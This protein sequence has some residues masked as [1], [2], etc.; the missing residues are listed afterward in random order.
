MQESKGLDAVGYRFTIWRDI[1]RIVSQAVFNNRLLQI[2][3]IAQNK[4]LSSAGT[5]RWLGKRSWPCRS[6]SSSR[7]FS[8]TS[9]KTVMAHPPIAARIQ[10]AVFRF[11]QYFA[12]SANRISRSDNIS[13]TILP[14]RVHEVE[15]VTPQLTGQA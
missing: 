9:A 11:D 10:P 14:P 1:P 4:G 3:C 15:N 2:L 12:P 13:Q 6:S 8:I 7:W 5:V